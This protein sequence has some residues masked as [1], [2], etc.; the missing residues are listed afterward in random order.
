MPPAPPWGYCLIR[1]KEPRLKECTADHGASCSAL[2]R[3]NLTIQGSLPAEVRTQLTSVRIQP[4]TMCA[5][6]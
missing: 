5:P 6:G 1:M 3:A 4:V 2:A